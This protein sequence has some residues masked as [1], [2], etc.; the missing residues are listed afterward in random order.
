[1]AAFTPDDALW[2]VP[3]IPLAA[4]ALRSPPARYFITTTVFALIAFG[5]YVLVGWASILPFRIWPDLVPRVSPE[6]LRVFATRLDDAAAI[7]ACP[8]MLALLWAAT[9]IGRQPFS[10]YLALRWPSRREIV[11]GLLATFA[12]LLIAK[13]AGYLTGE[14]TSDVVL[15]E[16]RSV[17]DSWWLLVLL[18]S[19]CVTAPLTEE[20]VVR[21]FLFRGWSQS[22]LGPTGAIVVTAVAWAALHSQYDLFYRSVIFAHGLMLGY[23]RYRSGSTW[24]TVIIHAAVNLAGVIEIAFF[25]G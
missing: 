24:L 7:I 5:I 6:E 13:L 1:V 15:N 8:M 23:F 12:L 2:V 14:S 18:I 22:F 21:G 9:R 19:L 17:K 11:R 10:D 4:A 16:Y 20:L 25:L 3:T